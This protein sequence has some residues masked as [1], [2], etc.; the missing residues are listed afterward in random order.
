MKTP[1]NYYNPLTLWVYDF[2][3]HFLTNLFWWRCPTDSVLFPFF[4]ANAGPVHMDVGVG[5][6]Y[7]PVSMRQSE[8]QRHPTARQN[9][10]QWPKQLTFV[11]MN[12]ACLAKASD[13]LG[14]PDRTECVLADIMK[15]INM[16]VKQVDSISMMYI[17]H[18]IPVSPEK[19]GC[20]FAHLKPYLKDS[21]TLFGSTVLG[22]GVS[23]NLIGSFLMWL[24]NAIGMFGNLEDRKEHFLK[25]LEEQFEHVESAVVG[26]VLLF[27]AQ[28][29]RKN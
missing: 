18:C 8:K 26:T 9:E 12:P 24:Y 2:F 20:T 10:A 19:K 22:K 27:K 5:T 1:N 14:L 7:F 25:P 21:G 17:L 28:K 29:P 16:D 4:Q 11:D 3:V 15:P 13:R 6:G 23:H